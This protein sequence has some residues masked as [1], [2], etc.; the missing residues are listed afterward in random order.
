FYLKGRDYYRRYHKQDNENAIELFQK[1]LKLDPNYAL[2]YSAL[3]EAQMRQPRYGFPEA[4]SVN[5]A[6]ESCNKAI[7]IDPNLPEAYNA[8]QKVY[9]HNGWSQKSFETLKKAVD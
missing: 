9:L 4:T 1:A 2:A 3:C 5:Q 7:A 8:L 6:V